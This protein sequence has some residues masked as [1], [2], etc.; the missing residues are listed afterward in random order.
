MPKPKQTVEEVLD[1]AISELEKEKKEIR[2]VLK[3][4]MCSPKCGF[5]QGLDTAIALAEELKN[6]THE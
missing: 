4:K 2:H 5:N 6:K 1:L 3:C